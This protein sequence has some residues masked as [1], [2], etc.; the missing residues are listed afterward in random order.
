MAAVLLGSLG[1][2]PQEGPGCW[3][4]GSP[5]APSDP[6]TPPTPLKRTPMF[7]LPSLG[8]IAS[9]QFLTLFVNRGLSLNC[10]LGSNC[11]GLWS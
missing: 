8:E 11:K 2:Q 3:T 5:E 1:L 10:V 7:C 6:P 9:I 4:S